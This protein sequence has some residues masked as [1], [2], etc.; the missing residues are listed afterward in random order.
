[1]ARDEAH[2]DSDVDLG[3]YYHPDRPPSTDELRRLAG[4]LDDR[5]LPDLVTD[6]GE[7]G[8]WINGGGWLRVKG[9]PVDWLY[10]DLDLVSRTIEECRAGRATCH[11][12]PGHPHGFHDHIYAGEVHYCRPLYDPLGRLAELKARVSEYPLLLKRALVKRFLWEADFS[13]YTCRKPAERG[14]VFYVSGCLFRCAAC[15]VQV[16]FAL[17]EHYFVNE[18]GS[19]KTA[20]SFALCPDGFE[21]TVSDMLAEPGRDAA[22]LQTSLRRAERLVEGVRALR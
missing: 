16:L 18:K 12:Q 7:W 20:G 2:P 5:H 8:P 22:G 15:L 13:L 21:E 17:N 9:R 1:M 14:E 6:F 3:I 4:G 10:R 11:Y 19:V